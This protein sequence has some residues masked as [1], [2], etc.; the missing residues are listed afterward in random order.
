MVLLPALPIICL[1]RKILVG[2]ATVILAN[3]LK[4]KEKEKMKKFIIVAIA[5]IA[6]AVGVY[7]FKNKSSDE[8][9]VSSVGLSG[10]S[11][12]SVLEY[13]PADT[14][15]FAGSLEPMSFDQAMELSRNMGFDFT[16]FV[17]LADQDE[18]K[19][20]D[21]APDAAKLAVGLYKVY[22]KAI[23][24]GSV[25]ALGISDELDIA[26]YTN[27]ALPVFRMALDG[28][29]TL[30]DTIASIEKEH[31]INPTV[32]NI[33][34][35]DYREYSFGK[36]NANGETMETP[37]SL[38]VST[39]NN[40]AVFSFN[41]KLDDAKDL[42][43]VLGAEKPA[44]SIVESDSLKNLM[45]ENGYLGHSL[46][47]VNNLG[48]VQGL[49]NPSAN[50][51]GQML[52]DLTAAYGEPNAL[53]ELQTPACHTEYSALAANWPT[54]SAGY[55]QLDAK[56]AKYKLLLEGTDASLL[57]T[58]Q[59]LQGHL[60]PALDNDQY[61]F[62]LGMG[63]N[64]SE[65]T[66]VVTDLWKRMT[67]EPFN[68]EPLAQMQAELKQSNPMQLGMLTGM[69]GGI[70]GIGFAVTDMDLNGLQNAQNNPMA[71]ADAMS[72]FMTISADNPMSLLQLGGMQI[73]ELATFELED[74]GE[75]KN[76]PL[77]LPV[78]VK[79]TLRGHDL[80]ISFGNTA[81]EMASSAKSNDSLESNGLLSFNMDMGAYFGMITQVANMEGNQAELDNLTEEEKKIFNMFKNVKGKISEKVNF[82][83]KG[84]AI[85]V[86]MHID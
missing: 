18:M 49:T 60:S 44:Q 22:I 11:K 55:T 61:L 46:F 59:K 33:A 53:A 63:L 78:E 51:F 5:L 47:Y 82:T 77:P 58:L 31:N 64:M 79:A 54:L 34:G 48:A 75:S 81:N 32:G 42:K 25:K 19:V 28:T 70:K 71:V 62:S 72:M 3:T 67:K 21:D 9:S 35:I 86:E 2:I 68:C 84:F 73:P 12:S 26:F 17:A 56:S 24:D 29:S 50:S 23:S 80:I 52:Q 13:V 1:S 85:D 38:V 66:G 41:T 16:S 14:V 30:A 39:A 15:V 6:V 65:V 8:G 36:V 74:G 45:E 37:V 83:D 10:A 27:G 57:E 4:L 76:L 43:L 20:D 69:V 7:I 40:Q